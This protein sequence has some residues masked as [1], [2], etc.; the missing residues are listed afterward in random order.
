MSLLSPAKSNVAKTAPKVLAAAAKEEEKRLN[1]RLPSAKHDA[2]R[3][4]CMRNE[5][6]MTTEVMRFIDEYISKNSR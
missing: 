4:A 6:D 2:F 3:R 5:T 1:V